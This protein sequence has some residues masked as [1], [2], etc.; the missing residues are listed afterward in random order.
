MKKGCE[1]VLAVSGSYPGSGPIFNKN[2]KQNKLNKPFGDIQSV[3]S[4]IQRRE[5]ISVQWFIE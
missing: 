2:Q 5:V 3:K 4:I 1:I